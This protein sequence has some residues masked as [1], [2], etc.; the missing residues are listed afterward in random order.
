MDEELIELL[1]V[2]VI[3]PFAGVDEAETAK[4][5]VDVSSQGVVGPLLVELSTGEARFEDSVDVEYRSG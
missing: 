5:E 1:V 3:V 4:L 2:E